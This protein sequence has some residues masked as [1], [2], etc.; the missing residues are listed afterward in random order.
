M[1]PRPTGHCH[2]ALFLIACLTFDRHLFR[3]AASG[4]CRSGAGLDRNSIEGPWMHGST[5]RG[6]EKDKVGAETPPGRQRTHRGPTNFCRAKINLDVFTY[7][8][9]MQILDQS[10]EGHDV[11]WQGKLISFVLLL[12]GG[13]RKNKPTILNFSKRSCAHF[14]HWLPGHQSSKKKKSKA[15]GARLPWA[16][17]KIS[18]GKVAPFHP[19]FFHMCPPPPDPSRHRCHRQSASW[20]ESNSESSL[21]EKLNAVRRRKGGKD[22]TGARKMESG[23]KLLATH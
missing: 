3:V 14:P 9:L 10:L 4:G 5:C 8:C 11:D 16:P 20:Q 2:C 22:K 21:W 13:R 6:G 7:R 12:L 19:S 23:R 15:M 1:Y 17:I 18:F